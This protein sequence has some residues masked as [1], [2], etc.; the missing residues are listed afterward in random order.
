MRTMRIPVISNLRGLAFLMLFPTSL[1]MSHAQRQW[2]LDECISYAIDHNINI[3]QRALDIKKSQVKLETSSNAWLPEVSARVGEQ[4]S[5]GNYNATTGSLTSPT[6]ADNNDLAYTTGGITATM[7]LFDGFKTTS[8]KRA[9]RFSLDA[10]TA[11][12]EKAR[13]DIGI[14][15][16]IRYLE[17]L[18]NKSMVDVALSQLDV[19]QK[20][21]QRAAALVED[22]KRPLSELKDVEA[23]VASDEYALAK[24]KGDLTL[25]LTDL[26]QMLNL[27][28]TEGFDVAPVEETS[29]P[30]MPIDYDGVIER[31][32][33]ILAAKSS[34]ESNKAQVKVARSGYYPTLYFEGYVKTYYVNMFHTDIGWGGFD[35]QFFDKNLNEV[36]GLHLSI[37]IFNRFQTRSN[38][39]T[40]KLN[41]MEQQLALDD[42]RQNLRTEMQK[43]YTNT[44]V[45]LDKLDAAQKAVDAAAVSVSYEQE[46]YDAGR[47]SV[48]DLINAQQKHMKA[49]QDA[50]QAKYEYFI[51]QRIL[52]F[53]K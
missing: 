4:F 36:V 53:Y 49:C 41:L 29:V 31:W 17:C 28:T 42:A 15:I 52:D 2:T 3:Q 45:A 6:V 33:S 48:F 22:G 26:A 8:Q 10:A 39:R 13:K 43:A 37:P 14:Q 20:L 25:S 11:N 51:R 7:N 35:K 27:P 19:S 5:F 1:T 30:P 46:R 34:I 23:S 50:V 24:A 16:A 9:D 38:I 18:C 12:L 32:P 47:S 40:A 21:C 44:I